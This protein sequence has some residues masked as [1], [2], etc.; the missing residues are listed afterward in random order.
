MAEKHIILSDK[1][2]RTSLEPGT[3]P[4]TQGLGPI[5][6]RGLCQGWPR[7]WRRPGTH[8]SPKIVATGQCGIIGETNSMDVYHLMQIK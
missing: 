8:P 7:P 5:L 3:F 2:N 1:L 6:G 4:G